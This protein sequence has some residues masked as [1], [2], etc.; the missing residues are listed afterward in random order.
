MEWAFKDAELIKS[1]QIFKGET[2]V[3]VQITL[4]I[5]RNKST[6]KIVQASG[7]VAFVH[8]I[9]SIALKLLHYQ[10]PKSRAASVKDL[11]EHIVN[12]VN[13]EA[14]KGVCVLEMPI[15]NSP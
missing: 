4:S 7:G 11:Y 13:K 14:R 5:T 9:D 8:R 1:R 10:L 2:M 12:S 15:I 3:R 6:R